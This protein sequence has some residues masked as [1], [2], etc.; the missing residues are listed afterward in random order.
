MESEGRRLAKIIDGG[1]YSILMHT[2]KDCGRKE[3]RRSQK[4]VR[5]P[6]A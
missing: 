1:R 2:E 5:A 6:E 4:E 3:M